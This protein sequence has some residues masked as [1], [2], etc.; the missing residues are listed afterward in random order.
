[1]IGFVEVDVKIIKKAYRLIK[2]EDSE[3]ILGNNEQVSKKISHLSDI[4]NSGA[5][6]KEKLFR[7]KQ[8]IEIKEILEELVYASF[9]SKNSSFMLRVELVSIIQDI[10]FIYEGSE[11]II[12]E[13]LNN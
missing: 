2:D 1:M 8:R 7:N 13:E 4:I 6:K 9:I 10:L 3:T 11:K 5:G 12:S